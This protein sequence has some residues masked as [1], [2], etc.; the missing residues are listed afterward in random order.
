MSAPTAMGLLAVLCSCQEVR[1]LYTGDC[2]GCGECCSRIL[3][4]TEHEARR[5]RSYAHE[6][7]IAARPEA[8]GTID[9]TCPWLTDD[10]ECAVYE[11]R[12]LACRAYRCDMH[13]KGDLS[14][15]PVGIERGRSLMDM[16]EVAS[17]DT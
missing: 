4:M 17:C 7:G 5:I 2:R 10:R 6:R 12:P 15:M 14:G 8:A 16:R 13:A 11:A 3:P 1:D 9:L